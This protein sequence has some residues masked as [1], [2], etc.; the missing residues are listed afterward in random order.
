M[1]K[2]Q[3]SKSQAYILIMTFM[4]GTT[5]AL[6]SYTESK[7]DTW[8]SLL[9]TLVLVTPIVIIYGNILNNH[10][11]KDLF[12]ILEHVFG[13][14][15]GRLIGAIYTFYFFHLGSICIRNMTEFIQVSSF[16]ET[17]QYFVAF[18]IGVLAIY[19]LK[20][21][22]EVMARVNR[23]VFPFLIFILIITLLFVIPRADPTNFLPILENGWQP[24][25]KHSLLISTF[26]FGETIVFMSFFNTVK[27]K[28]KAPKIYLKGIYLGGLVLFS[29]IVRNI[30]MLG[31][32]S[33]SSSTFPS[34][35]AVSL[36]NIGDFIRGIEVVIAIV[37]TIAGFIKVS[38]CLFASCIGIARLFNF[39][40]Y[41]WVSA[42]LALLMISLSF[43]LYDSTMHMV[44]WVNIYQYYAIPFQLIIPVLVLIFGKL[45][46]NQTN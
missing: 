6:S 33:L 35:D 40:D 21:G 19:M 29:V 24:V 16:P 41:K 20:S 5:S 38:I 7:Q 11:G 28:K 22:L 15:I 37:I 26:P 13:K 27:E 45:K 32:P 44:E 43:I 46:K 30:L 23:F 4:I 39:D 25:I 2:E 17:P 36:I 31:F 34:H 14:I 42:P 10:P 9:A 3:I 8:I 12:Q 1:R 18:F